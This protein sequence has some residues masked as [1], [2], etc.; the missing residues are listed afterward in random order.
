VP[1]FLSAVVR[2]AGASLAVLAAPLDRRSIA[3]A[4][5]E[6]F[7]RRRRD[8]ENLRTWRDLEPRLSP[9]EAPAQAPDSVHAG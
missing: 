6:L 4:Q 8:L 9:G 5:G 1:L 2:G 7:E 3:N